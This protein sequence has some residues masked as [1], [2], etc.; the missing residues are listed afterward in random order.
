MANYKRWKDLAVKVGSFQA[1]N[2]DTKN[3]YE[4]VGAVL[5]D[6]QELMILLKPTF[7]PAG[8]PREAGRDTI[9]L[10]LFDPK[11]QA[12]GAAAT[13]P[14]IPAPAPAPAAG[15]TQFDDDVPF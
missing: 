1:A 6:G 15:S 11:P 3:R 14:G 12:N 9:V 10:S 5:R 2:G 4:N 7:N 8:V 13:A